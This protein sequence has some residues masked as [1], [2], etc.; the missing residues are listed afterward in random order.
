MLK[1]LVRCAAV[2]ITALIALVVGIYS[3]AADL[4]GLP[5]SDY[6]ASVR[7]DGSPL[8][9]GQI[10][11]KLDTYA[12]ATG[13][14]IVRVA[15]APDDFLNKRVAFFFGSEEIKNAEID[16]FSPTMS[17]SMSKSGDLGITSLNGVYGLSG[18]EMQAASFRDWLSSELKA[19]AVLTKK[20]AVGL[21]SYA[22]LTVGAWVP[23]SAAILL[24]GGTILSWY[25]LRARGRELR[26]MAGM[27]LSHVVFADLRSLFAALAVPVLGTY[28]AAVAVVVTAGFGR[29]GYF[30]FTLLLFIGV[31]TIFTVLAALLLGLLTLPAVRDIAARRPSERGSWAISELLKVAAVMIVAAILPT[32]SG[33]VSNASAAS[34]QGGIW[35]SMGDGVALRIANRLGQAEEAAL[36][37]LTRDMVGNDAA[38]FSMSLSSTTV[39]LV[40]EAADAD[41]KAMGYD[42]V[43]LADLR[44]LDTVNGTSGASWGPITA[45]QS[46]DDLPESVQ[47]KLVPT[48]RLWTT[49]RQGP[50]VH[51]YENTSDVDIVVSGSMAGTLDK[52]RH[53]LILA[54]KDVSQ[55]DNFFLA[56]AVSRGN[57]VFTDPD[58]VAQLVNERDMAAGIL[59]IDRIADLG[60]Y[61]A[62]SKQRNAQ[63]G[64]SAIALA[65]LALVMCVAVTAWIFAL[66]RRR[67]W[68]VQRTAGKSWNAILLPRLL[69]E[70][71]AATLFGVVMAL[72]FVALDPSSIWI[73]GF[74]PVFYFAITWCIHHWAATTAFRTALARRG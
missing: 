18:S 55:F 10:I 1:V 70:S 51:V 52:S 61:D 46:I 12:D 67:R 29:L 33:I 44:Y 15:S 45:V 19:D 36:A 11:N 32:V 43:V 64:A 66:L 37:G 38:M 31:L 26:I 9:R 5:D 49:N 73:S 50:D 6:V 3:A 24:L 4:D 23:V 13:M 34:S 17:G 21:L 71:I 47:S 22:L 16:W 58:R 35:G 69:W 63:L 72:A 62:Q 68:F 53:P 48:L 74:A 28:A 20:T 41:L 27:R 39:D 42:G 40:D 56:S 30:I 25:V 14:G 60:L 2:A 8:S 65:V 59:S 54:V 57:V 7:F